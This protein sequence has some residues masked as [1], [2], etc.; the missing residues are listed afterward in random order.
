MWWGMDISQFFDDALGV[1]R[2]PEEAP[3]E[4]ENVTDEV[5]DTLHQAQ[6]TRKK[7][8][9]SNRDANNKR[10]TEDALTDG[11]EA[12][13]MA[14][15]ATEEKNYSDVTPTAKSKADGAAAAAPSLGQTSELPVF[16]VDPFGHTHKISL[17]S[18]TY[19]V[20]QSPKKKKIVVLTCLPVPELP[21]HSSVKVQRGGTESHPRARR[22]APIQHPHYRWH[23]FNAPKLCPDGST[24]MCARDVLATKEEACKQAGSVSL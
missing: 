4:P 6:A 1:Y 20:S 12:H 7:D 13:P 14:K 17:K 19:R 21:I 22:A 16:F 2:S 9:Q 23:C 15:P 3:F 18:C 11:Q 10:S 5:G 24:R 8:D